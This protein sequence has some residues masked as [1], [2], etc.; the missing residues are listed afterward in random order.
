MNN[1]PADCIYKQVERQYTFFNDKMLFY[2][3]TCIEA[4]I[5]AW[6]QLKSNTGMLIPGFDIETFH[7]ISKQ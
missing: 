4:L 6:N 7:R 5:E 2:K 1:E 3:L